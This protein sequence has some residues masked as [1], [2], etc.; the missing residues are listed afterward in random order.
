[1]KEGCGCL[2]LLIM[3]AFAICIGN[4]IS[5]T[6]DTPS[7]ENAQY[8]ITSSDG[9]FFTDTIP[10]QFNNTIQIS[11]WYTY[12]F[13]GGIWNAGMTQEVNKTKTLGPETNWKIKDRITKEII[14]SA[15]TKGE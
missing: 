5:H 3:L 12:K 15:K 1:M 14:A 11:Q 8:K 10:L 13:I 2:V 7:V 9:T 4:N 6:F